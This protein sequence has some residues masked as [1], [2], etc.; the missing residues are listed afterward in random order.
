MTIIRAARERILPFMKLL[1]GKPGSYYC[2]ATARGWRSVRRNGNEMRDIIKHVL[3][4][5][6]FSFVSIR[7]CVVVSNM[8]NESPYAVKMVSIIA[9]IC[10]DNIAIVAEHITAALSPTR[11]A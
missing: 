8:E 9:T 1:Q 10:C 3:Y 5:K 6:S 2:A 7:V 4:A 11:R